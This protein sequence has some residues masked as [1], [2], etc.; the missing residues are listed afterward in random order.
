M[1][2]TMSCTDSL[3]THYPETSESGYTSENITPTTEARTWSS[4]GMYSQDVSRISHQQTDCIAEPSNGTITECQVA[5]QEQSL[6]LTVTN[7]ENSPTQRNMGQAKHST[8]HSLFM[9]QNLEIGRSGLEI[10]P[11]NTTNNS[12]QNV[13]DKESDCNCH[14]F[15]HEPLDIQAY[16]LEDKKG[17]HHESTKQRKPWNFKDTAQTSYSREGAS[18]MTMLCSTRV[19]KRAGKQHKQKHPCHITNNVDL[20]DAYET[21][22]VMHSDYAL[23]SDCEVKS[24]NNN[25]GSIAS[26]LDIKCTDAIAH[27]VGINSW[28]G[29]ELNKPNKTLQP[30]VARPVNLNKTQEAGGNI[31]MPSEGQKVDTYQHMSKKLSEEPLPRKIESTKISFENKS[32]YLHAD[33]PFHDG[34]LP[35]ETINQSFS[36]VFSE[37]TSLCVAGDQTIT[38]QSQVANARIERERRGNNQEY[39]NKQI[40]ETYLETMASDFSHIHVTEDFQSG[41]D[42]E[43]VLAPIP[44][45]SISVDNRSV[46]ISW[47]STS[48]ISRELALL[49]NILCEMSSTDTSKQEIQTDSACIRTKTREPMRPP[50]L[51]LASDTLPTSA[52]QGQCKV[53]SGRCFLQRKGSISMIAEN[54]QL[55]YHESTISDC[56]PKP[57]LVTKSCEDILSSMPREKINQRSKAQSMLCLLT[58]N[59]SHCSKGQEK[60]V[61]FVSKGSFIH[62]PE[63][64]Q[65]TV[66]AMKLQLTLG[67]C[68]ELLRLAKKH[69]SVDL[70]AAAYAVMSDNY[71]QVLRDSSLYGQLNGSERDQILQLRLRGKKVLGT[72]TL[73]NIYGL[74]SSSQ[75]CPSG[76]EL[77]P[78][79]PTTGSGQKAWLYIFHVE[80]NYWHPLTPVPEEANLKGCGVCTM[81]NYLFLA[82][83]IQGQGLNTESSNKVFCY[84]PLT[85]IWS[86]VAPM[87][88][89]RSQFKLVSVDGYLYA[90]GGECLYTV[91]RYDPRFNK[92]TFRASLP[93]GSFAVAHEAAACNGDIYISGGH[94]FYRLFRYIPLR[95]LWEEC[96]YNTSRKRSS[97]M[98]AVRSFLYRFDIHRD[99][100]VSVFK[101][102]TIAKVWNESAS[103]YLGS[104]LPFRCT[105]L[106]DTIYCL[107][108][109]M[110]ARFLANERPPRFE[111]KSLCPFS[112]SNAGG[113]LCPFVLSLP[114]FGT[115]QTPV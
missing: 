47:P 72:L 50:A 56:K 6:E 51:S 107:N 37:R 58:E 111:S 7:D 43:E 14:L 4:L 112:D 46:E 25:D 13:K 8:S 19:T 10:L 30:V 106:G 98:V 21:E 78:S 41:F 103:L 101:Y 108:K 113:I 36:K 24:V 3:A 73:E 115:F 57:S 77:S 81:H 1:I 105:V 32:K 102:N 64:L 34:L 62:I 22:D 100:G 48:G 82:G 42:K 66:D 70:Q 60:L 89:A 53:P 29:G 28:L 74:R 45:S 5:F 61:Q 86:Q 88:Q 99:F 12:I 44:L 76:H 38:K 67:N 114:Q 71:F 54:P 63:T 84:N 83:G 15:S 27:L 97:D 69:G 49:N 93:K 65:E 52:I 9:F 26:D 55:R 75:S 18:C 39:K 80:E 92:W 17:G 59:Y 35:N 16:C 68:L 109:K 11:Y 90:I 33:D 23:E 91:E 104:S 79:S 87:N 96:P 2:N 95:D 31:I 110:T 94:L 40:R 20:T 85:E